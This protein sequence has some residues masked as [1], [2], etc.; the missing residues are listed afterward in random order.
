MT[1]DQKLK[2]KKRSPIA[3]LHHYIYK[4]YPYSEE[5]DRFMRRFETGIRFKYKAGHPPQEVDNL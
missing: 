4:D 3:H 1:L 2:I 5:N